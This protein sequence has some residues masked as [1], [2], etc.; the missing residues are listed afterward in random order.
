MRNVALIALALIAAPL[1]ADDP[2]WQSIVVRFTIAPDGKLHVAEQVTVAVPPSVQRLERTYWTDAEQDV[3]FDAITLYD[4]GRTIPLL[5]S[6][7]L[8][9]AHRF[10]QSASP[11]SVVW[12]VRDKPDVPAGVRTLTYVIESRISDAVIPA[13]SIPRGRQSHENAG[14]T[15]DPRIRLREAISI[16]REALKNPKHRYLVDF[17]FEMPPPSTNGTSI[18]LQIYWPPGWTPVHEITPDTVA[19]D[20][21]RVRHLFE[22]DGRHLLTGIN[23][24]RH[25]IR[26]AALLGFPILALL[27]WLAFVL[28]ETLRRHASGSE[29]VDERFLREHV[30]N[31]A[32]EVIAARW[33]GRNSYPSIEQFLRRLERQGKVSITIDADERVSLRLLVPRERLTS[34]E[35]SGIDSLIP[36]GWETSSDD[37]QRRYAGQDFD[38]TDSIWAEIQRI[39]TSSMMRAAV[40]WYAKLISIALFVT[41]LYFAIQESVR[42]GREPAVLAAGVVGSWIVYSLSPRK[43]PLLLIPLVVL[44]GL[45]VFLHFTAD[46][47]PTY[48]ASAGL[49]LMFLGTYSAVLARSMTRYAPEVAPLAHARAWVT[50]ELKS[51]APRLRDEWIPWLLALD[52]GNNIE[53]WRR[54]NPMSGQWTGNAPPEPEEEWGGALMT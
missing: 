40:P 31:E 13:W 8:D 16:W 39:R 34:F 35:R 15:H 43:T 14:A 12:S 6:G 2:D 45:M 4:G 54:R 24:S 9:H 10:R 5:D 29:E 30:L 38:P 25:A 3:T 11:G 1:F 33:S 17:Q 26:M 23:T 19:S 42:M 7:D 21:W 20:Q 22:E 41:G 53:R 28:R 44:T 47:S 50:N 51:P 32:P 46:L 52:L 18:Q 37:I 27:F 36:D 49:A 48:F